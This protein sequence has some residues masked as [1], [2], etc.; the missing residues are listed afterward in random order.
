MTNDR[1]GIL[2]C[3]AAMII[4]GSSLATS[5][6][7]VDFP[8]YGGQAARYAVAAAALL[9]VLR[10]RRIPLIRPTLR[11]WAQLA[12]VA[13]TGLALFNVCVIQG[14][15]R[16]S[17]SLVGAVIGTAPIVLALAGGA[18][19]RGNRR[20]MAAAAVV[21]TGVLIVQGLGPVNGPGLLFAVGALAGEVGFSLLAVPLLPTLGPLRVSA[22]VCA[23]A[24]PM[25]LIVGLLLP[26]PLFAVPTGTELATLGY[27]AVMVTAVAFLLWYNGLSRIGPARAGLFCAV[28][29]IAAAVTSVALGFEP[30]RLHVV[31]GALTVGLGLLVGTLRT[32]GRPAETDTSGDGLSGSA[33]GAR[34]TAL[35]R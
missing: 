21:V 4:V 25:M 30:L 16:L 20:I 11:Q 15:A 35:S 17:P 13:A 33:R 2:S 23:I 28:M 6:A 14:D 1:T 27:L 7:L 22:Y 3:I 31:I 32:G 10:F 34:S 19:R 9:A 12:A 8:I 5:A 18:G 26:G 29:P 24:V